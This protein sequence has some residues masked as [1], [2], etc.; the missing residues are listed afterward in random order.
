V[1]ASQGLAN[2]LLVAPTTPPHRRVE[3]AAHCTGFV[4]YVS[5]RGITGERDKLPGETI[6]GV[7]ELRTHVDT[8]ICVGFGISTPEMVA[9]ACEVAD[10]AIVG[11][12]IVH[13]ITDSRD[14]TTEKLVRRVGDF[15]GELLAPVL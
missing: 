2:V 15:V 9:A 14:L 6:A 4:Y 10:G 3:I 1:A 11:S 12:A 8:P 5:V 7:T 13:R